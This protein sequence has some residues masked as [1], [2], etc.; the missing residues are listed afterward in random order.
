ME[1]KKNCLM[2][3]TSAKRLRNNLSVQWPLFLLMLG[4]FAVLAAPSSAFAATNIQKNAC[5]PQMGP[6]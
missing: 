4:V 6:I 1:R 5:Y 3:K 2:G